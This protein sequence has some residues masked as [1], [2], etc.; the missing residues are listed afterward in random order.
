MIPTLTRTWRK[1]VK[2]SCS[3]PFVEI[4]RQYYFGLVQQI[5][6]QYLRAIVSKEDRL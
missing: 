2:I 3:L 1:R 6:S 5:I 4:G